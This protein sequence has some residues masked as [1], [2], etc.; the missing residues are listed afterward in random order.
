M[1]ENKTEKNIRIQDY[2][3]TTDHPEGIR[4]MMYDMFRT[5]PARTMGQWKIADD[6]INKT[7]VK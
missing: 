3:K 5:A 2:L 4:K 7:R 6:H 1:A